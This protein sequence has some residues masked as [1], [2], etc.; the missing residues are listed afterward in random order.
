MTFNWTH[1]HQWMIE[2]FYYQSRQSKAQWLVALNGQMETQ[3]SFQGNL[4]SARKWLR[5][6]YISFQPSIGTS[7]SSEI[8]RGG[9]SRRVLDPWPMEDAVEKMEVEIS[10]TTMSATMDVGKPMLF[11][12]LHKVRD[13]ASNLKCIAVRLHIGKTK[14]INPQFK[15]TNK[16]MN[17]RIDFVGMD[18]NSVGLS[19]I[20]ISIPSMPAG[21]KTNKMQ[22]NP[23][24]WNGLHGMDP[25]M[26]K[27]DVKW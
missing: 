23:C 16:H 6:D 13:C 10:F 1:S 25:W 17:P 2:Q 7:R 18:R 5:Q 26:T 8:S 12:L 20:T 21:I 15:T 22:M 4:I 24:E 9:L 14:I 19:T 11:E 3:L 27:E